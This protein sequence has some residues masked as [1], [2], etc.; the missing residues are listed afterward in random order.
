[1]KSNFLDRNLAL[2]TVRVTE[3]AAL[4]SSL[5]MGRGNETI[6]D[7]SAVN[8]MRSFLNNIP[9]SGKIAIGEGER[10]KAPMLFIGEKVG[11]GG[12][13][14]D[15]ALDP[16]EGTTITAKGGENALSVLAL[17]EEGTFLH[18]PDIYM[19]KIAY[20]KTYQD[21]NIDIEDSPKNIINKFSKFSGI[22]TENVCVCILDRLRHKDLILEVRS[23]GARIKLI[24]DGDVSAVI[25]TSIEDSGID[26]YMGIGG[27]PEGVLAAAALRCIGGKMFSKLLFDNNKDFE[28]ANTMGINDKNKIYSIYDL[29]KGDVMFSATGVTDGTLLKGVKFKNNFATTESVVMRSK[30]NTIRYVKAVHDLNV[31]DL[32]KI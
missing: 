29:V 27:S 13:K 28:R 15:I 17:G 3:I 5:H 4:A 8:A 1:M 19:Q 21:L 16:L 23:T 10:D 20:G 24:P 30:T 11:K 9:I 2:E 18:S 14:V 26:I 22:K 7:E 25:A 6:A 31:K 32:N 12:P